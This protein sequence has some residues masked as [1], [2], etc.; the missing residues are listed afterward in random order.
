MIPQLTN[1]LW[2]STW[3]T[4]LVAL[5]VGAQRRLLR[6]PQRRRALAQRGRRDGG[7]ELA[8]GAAVLDREGVAAEVVDVADPRA[9]VV[10][11]AGR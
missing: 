6:E 1:H 3:Y 7:D 8:L 11:L 10:E 5:L 2:Q 4:L 9:V